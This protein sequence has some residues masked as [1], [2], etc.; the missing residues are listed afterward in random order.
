MPSSLLQFHRRFPQPSS[1]LLVVFPLSA[2]SFLTSF[3]MRAFKV[4]DKPN[5]RLDFARKLKVNSRM[6]EEV[7][8][9]ALGESL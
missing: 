6:F 9:K 2:F 7:T 8:V 4:S 5:S 1:K 3:L